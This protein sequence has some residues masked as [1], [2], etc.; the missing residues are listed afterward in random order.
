[1]SVFSSDVQEALNNAGGAWV[2]ASEFEGGLTLQVIKVEKVRPNNPKYG[3][4]DKNY[5]VKEEIL[6]EGETFRYHFK[7][8]EGNERQHDS[9][10]APMCIGFQQANVEPEDWVKITRTGKTDKTRYEVVK[11]AAPEKGKTAPQSV[12]TDDIDPD[13]IPF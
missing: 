6:D 8:A 4:D 7:D 3:A 11:V 1:M 13:S 10:S 9:S 2:K 12:T 5:L